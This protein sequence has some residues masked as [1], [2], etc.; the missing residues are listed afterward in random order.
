LRPVLAQGAK[1]LKKS[2]GVSRAMR[3]YAHN[4]R[5]A[6]ELAGPLFTNLRDRGFAES[7]LTFLYRGAAAAARFDKDS[8]ILPAFSVINE[9][10]MAATKPVPGCEATFT[11]AP[12]AAGKTRRHKARKQ[13]PVSESAPTVDRGP[14]PVSTPPKKLPDALKPVQDL[15]NQIVP[16]TPKPLPDNLDSLANY[17][18]G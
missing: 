3:E 13:A 2:V 7:L 12:T 5:G 14:G 9:C 15:L 1:T 16:P 4:S 10:S 11:K 8:H 18:L 6:A 17:L